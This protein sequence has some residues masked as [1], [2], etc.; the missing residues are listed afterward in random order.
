M[1]ANRV[2]NVNMWGGILSLI[3]SPRKKLES[4]IRE[5]NKSGWNVS[6]IL[7]GKFNFIFAFISTIVL[8]ITVFIYQP[9]PG[10]MVIFEKEEEKNQKWNN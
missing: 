7:P 10:Y 2:I 4:T 6:F 1:K 5:Q 3:D 8:V 9:L